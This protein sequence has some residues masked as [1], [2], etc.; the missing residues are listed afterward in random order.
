MKNNEPKTRDEELYNFIK[1]SFKEN[2]VPENFSEG[3]KFF[4]NETTDDSICFAYDFGN[5]DNDET[6]MMFFY[7]TTCA[8]PPKYRH[9]LT[10][11]YS[12]DIRLLELD[13]QTLVLNLTDDLSIIEGLKETAVNKYEFS[14]MMLSEQ[15]AYNFING[16]GQKSLK[17]ETAKVFDK[18]KKYTARYNEFMQKLDEKVENLTHEGPQE[19]E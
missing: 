19:N 1:K 15:I 13:Y 18:A 8:V 17:V 2:M 5:R 7:P 3:K 4:T 6:A 11:E 14:R 12:D 9:H 10:C 16:L